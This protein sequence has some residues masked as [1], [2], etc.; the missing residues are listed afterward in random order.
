MGAA[1]DRFCTPVQLERRKVSAGRFARLSLDLPF[2]TLAGIIGGP[3]DGP[4]VLVVHGWNSQAEFFQPILSACVRQG[5]R[6]YA[7]DMPAHAQTREANPHKPTST[8]PEW[9]ET[10]I[11]A[12]RALNVAEWRCIVAHSFGGLAASFALG[13]RPWATQLPARARSLALLAGAAGMPTVIDSYARATDAPGEDIADISAGV[14]SACAVPL[15][16]ITVA[17]VASS[18]PDRLLLV[19]DPAD[20][21][22]RLADLKAV[23]A[24][25]PPSEEIMRPGAGH[26]EILFQLDVGRAVAKFASG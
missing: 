8:L 16:E 21:V 15:S 9:V 22:T 5:L 1:F 6:V 10:L 23:L 24:E 7:F 2:G 25:H 19:H 26:D 3:E 17:S 18:L 12:S 14:S 20:D 11:D 13:R 4:P